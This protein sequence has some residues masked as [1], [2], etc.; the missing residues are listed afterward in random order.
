MYTAEME[1]MKKIVCAT[2]MRFDDALER[3][4]NERLLLTRLPIKLI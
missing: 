1:G 4:H 2:E 3:Y